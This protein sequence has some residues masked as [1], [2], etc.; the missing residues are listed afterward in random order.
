[1]SK[2]SVFEEVGG[3]KADLAAPV[4]E[5]KRLPWR[6]GIAVWL[7]LLAGLVA[8]MV[9]V[10]GLTRLTDSGL[11][12]TVWD[13]VMGAI[14][15]L[16]AAD[17]Q[18][19]F[20]AY[21]TTTE[22]Q[23]QN[24][25]M[26]L[27]DFKPIFWWEWGHRFLGRFIGVV[28]LV[29]FLIFFAARRIPNGW[30]FRLILP[31]LLGGIQGAVG[32][33]MVASGLDKL[34]VA[35]YRLAVHLGLAFVIFMLLCWF[36]LKVRLDEVA[37]LQ[38]RRR[39]VGPVLGLGGA[40]TALIFLQI[41][42]G[43]L[44]AGID[45]GRGY[46]DWPLMQGEF[47]PAESF[48]LMPIWRNFFE[49]AALV[50]FTHRMLGYAVFVLGVVFALR[51]MRSSEGKVARWGGLVGLMVL[52]QVVIGIVTVMNAAPLHIA[53]FHQGG[54]LVLVFLLM[55]AKFEAAYPGETRIARA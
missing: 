45:A 33:W 23:E 34:D 38:A 19:A 24:S 18:A 48:D 50:Q 47:L 40:L 4:P 31:G 6:R 55:R 12:I 21:Q 37:S 27:S 7:W 15:P 32:W 13:P 10:G 26:T 9:L 5:A 54:A 11:S 20:A 35:S 43:A 44:V 14:P 1:M 25:W 41:L 30:T 46:V 52:A 51:A 42:S 22:F 49:N 36:A 39:R 17:W 2:R 28:W 29:G 3:T 8:I 53:I 16:S